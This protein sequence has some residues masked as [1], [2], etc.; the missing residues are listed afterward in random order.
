MLDFLREYCSMTM[1]EAIEEIGLDPS[2]LDFIVE[3]REQERTLAR[4]APPSK[5][6]QEQGGTWLHALRTKQVLF[7]PFYEHAL[8]YL[9]TRG[10]TDETIK[11]FDLQY[12]PLFDDSWKQEDAELWGLDPNDFEEG[13]I[14]LPEGILIPWYCGGQLWKLEVRRLKG[15]KEHSRYMVI[16]GSQEYSLFNQDAVQPDKSVVL[17]ESALDAIAGEQACG[18]LAVFVATGGT[19]KAKCDKWVR[20]LL[21]A[22]CVLVAFDDDEEDEHGKRAGDEGAMFWES[23]LSNAIRWLPWSHDISDMLK[24]GK[25]IREWV[26]DGIAC[27]T[28]S[29]RARTFSVPTEST[30]PAPTIAI[31]GGQGQPDMPEHSPAPTH[32]IDADPVSVEQITTRP[33]YTPCT[34]PALPRAQCPHGVLVERK[35]LMYREICN[36]PATHDGWCEAHALSHRFLE[37]GAS[38]GYPALDLNQYRGVFAG[39][40]NWEGYAE[41][42][43]A[44]HLASDIRVLEGILQRELVHA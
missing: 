7:H 17:C 42:F 30:S 13:K 8:S 12:L 26:T 16:A 38:L 3:E 4:E 2:E 19:G 25:D 36:Q 1:L 9:H 6:W 31:S 5:K 28:L 35:S 34:L 24:E 10:L 18:D 41:I 43:N 33:R 23:S 22:S 29:E 15:V 32:P 21:Q 11:R 14:K 37:L 20:H 40:A 27:Y 39:C 44:R